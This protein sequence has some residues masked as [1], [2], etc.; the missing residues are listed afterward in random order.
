MYDR[1]SKQISCLPVE[2]HISCS[3][4]K[5][6]QDFQREL[7]GL[8]QVGEVDTDYVQVTEYQAGNFDLFLIDLPLMQYLFSFAL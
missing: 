3:G 8:L 4:N 1:Q 2:D 5:Q 7:Q 6:V